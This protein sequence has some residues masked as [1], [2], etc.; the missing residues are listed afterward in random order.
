MVRFLYDVVRDP[1]FKSKRS[2]ILLIMSYIGNFASGRVP[3]SAG[4]SAVASTIGVV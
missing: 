4:A 2:L 3:S 1:G